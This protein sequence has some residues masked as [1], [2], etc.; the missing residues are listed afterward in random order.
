MGHL[1]RYE[2]FAH[3][4]FCQFVQQTV[5]L[6]MLSATDASY[7]FADAI[8]LDRRL[9]LNVSV[10]ANTK[11]MF[12]GSGGG[13]IDILC[14]SVEDTELQCRS[15]DDDNDNGNPNWWG[16]N[17]GLV[18]IILLLFLLVT[19]V[20]ST[21]VYLK[22]G[23]AHRDPELSGKLLAGQNE[24]VQIQAEIMTG[25][26]EIKADQ[27]TA[28]ENTE[29]IVQ[30]DARSQAEIMAGQKEIRAD[31]TMAQTAV[32]TLLRDETDMPTLFIMTREKGK[33]TRA[34]NVAHLFNPKNFG[35]I[36]WR[37][38]F[39]DPITMRKAPT[40]DGGR[41]YKLKVQ[42]DWLITYAPALRATL[43]VLTAALAVG[44]VVGITA[45][46]AMRDAASGLGLTSAVSITQEELDE[47][48]ET[49]GMLGDA[50]KQ[51]Y[52][53]RT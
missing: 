23:D 43:S 11:S 6:N 3:V 29:A 8:S 49:V 41:G 37:L 10:D 13:C 35:K 25:Q 46:G 20:A 40:G 42:K 50:A 36:T 1:T 26:E 2:L 52:S 4:R 9:C 12:Q 51:H 15:D 48:Q 17:E 45:D 39:V 5:E 28:L 7:M 21:A 53:R 22:R 34:K 33:E 30:Q 32:E 31:Q 44:R 47:L 24:I 38:W 16:G 18:T 14:G 19:F 27:I